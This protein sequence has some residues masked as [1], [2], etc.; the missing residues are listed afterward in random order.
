VY[1]ESTP[2][3]GRDAWRGWIEGVNSPW[4]G[5]RWET[6]ECY[7]VG[8]DR[9]LHLGQWGGAGA[10]S[11]IGTSS[12]LTGLFTVRN[13][14]VT[15]C[16]Y[17]FDHE[18]ALRAVG[19]ANGVL[20]TVIGAIDAFNRGDV[21]AMLDACTPEV[22]WEEYVGEENAFPGLSS[23]YRGREG[24]K[25]WFEN[26]IRDPFDKAYADC[27]EIAEGPDGR[28]L[29]AGVLTT[30]GRA[31]GVETRLPFWQ[32]WWLEELKCARRQVFFDRAS[33]LE[34]A[35]LPDS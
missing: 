18:R 22:D 19:L 34:A 27:H 26:V 12:D 7:A 10:A 9:V 17:Y 25:E 13:G 30:R 31:S 14:L 16:E 15:R 1:P 2:V 32:I 24:V 11:G 6:T 20:E 8:A 5:A 3:H 33:G 29:I 21:N 4:I 35:G 28:V 23:H